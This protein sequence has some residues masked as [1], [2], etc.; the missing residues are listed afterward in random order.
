MFEMATFFF[1]LCENDIFSVFIS[2]NCF[3]IYFCSHGN[4]E[5]DGFPAPLGFSRR[6]GP[7]EELLL[8]YISI[9]PTVLIGDLCSIRC[10]RYTTEKQVHKRSCHGGEGH[11]SSSFL[12]SELERLEGSNRERWVKQAFGRAIPILLTLFLKFVWG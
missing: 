3:C 12:Y 1:L 2:S 4:L 7:R 9:Y 5:R 10:V 6:E 8:R 11:I